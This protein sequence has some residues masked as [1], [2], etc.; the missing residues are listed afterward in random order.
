M[1]F[2]SPDRT[3]AFPKAD[4]VIVVAENL[5]DEHRASI[6]R[7]LSHGATVVVVREL[8]AAAQWLAEAPPEDP[9]LVQVG[10]LEIHLGERRVRW[11]GRQLGLSR[12]EVEIMSHLARPPGRASSFAEI[13]ERVWG[14]RT[15]VEPTVV[16]CA[17]RRLR[18]KLEEA[19]ATVRV[20]SVRGFGLRLVPE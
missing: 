20:E 16:H 19:Q 17:V 10:D 18:R 15:G 11:R 2:R 7:L 8:G 12:R 6:N 13:T 4:Y 3:K 1:P 9:G 5:D 14:T